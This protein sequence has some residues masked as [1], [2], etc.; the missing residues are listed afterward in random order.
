M[1]ALNSFLVIALM[2]GVT[3]LSNAAPTDPDVNAEAVKNEIAPQPDGKHPMPPMPPMQQHK[4]RQE[5]MPMM[6]PSI[7][8]DGKAKEDLKNMLAKVENPDIKKKLIE[9][10]KSDVALEKAIID[11]K[12]SFINSLK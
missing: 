7:A 9:K 11:D 8:M 10:L 6:L 5:Q 4:G 12:A 2:A 3:T 1:K